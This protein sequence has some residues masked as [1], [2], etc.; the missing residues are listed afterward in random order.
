MKKFKHIL[1]YEAFS[2]GTISKTLSF[3]EKKI[4]KSQRN[5]FLSGLKK[6]KDKYD[7]P[8]DLIDDKWMDYMP[9]KDALLFRNTESAKND[10]GV[11]HIKFWFSIEK[12]YL[13]YSA[14]GNKEV[15]F[16]RGS[17]EQKI[18]EPFT[19]GEINY[20]LSSNILENKGK[21]IPVKDYFSLNHLDVCVMYVGRY[22]DLSDLG[23]TTIWIDDERG[24]IFGI[25][26][27]ESGGA[28]YDGN[29]RQYGTYS[30][31]MG[32]PRKPKIDHK[33]L[34]KY[35]YDDEPLRVYQEEVSSKAI[36][37]FDYNLPVSPDGKI[38]SWGNQGSG[39]ISEPKRIEEA[40]FAIILNFDEMINS[41]YKKPSVKTKERMESR[42]GAS[43]LMSDDDVRRANIEK[44]TSQLL[45]KLGVSKNEFNPVN[46]NKVITM[47]L[48]GEFALLSIRLGYTN[49][50]NDFISDLSSLI[51]IH[52]DIDEY[53]DDDIEEYYTNV[54]DKYK[55]LYN[56]S[57]KK[58]NKLSGTLTDLIEYYKDEKNDSRFGTL[59]DGTNPR[60][61]LLEICNKVFE[62]GKKITENISKLPVNTIA[63]LKMILYKMRSIK[64][65]MEN[66]SEFYIGWVEYMQYMGSYGE[67]GDTTS[68]FNRTSKSERTQV[69]ESLN[70][71]DKYI[72]TLFR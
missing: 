14:V 16:E 12:G 21:L 24:Q 47:L 38:T 19:E 59:R 39:T 70:N 51:S 50:L 33:K 11:S 69:L 49:G 15:N 28:P 43:R 7:Y 9:K 48:Q 56:E 5:S 26:N 8:I 1:V 30:W 46:L 65:I 10:Y 17:E 3:I 61:E 64:Q 36:N 63:D 58:R 44:Y 42:E 45:N 23:K 32:T 71:L 67:I 4:G 41:E 18:N 40:D 29:W 60:L 62:I 68:R 6:I 20:I 27:I 35:I 53:T 57:S 54:L 52:K 22:T 72:D 13:G 37:P 34:H 55:R 25:Q 66:E 2:S 31:G